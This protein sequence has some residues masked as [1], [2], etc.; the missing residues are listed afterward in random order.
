ML[1]NQLTDLSNA[2]PS[3]VLSCSNN[4]LK[5]LDLSKND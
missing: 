4:P 2:M 1:N 5:D 3:T